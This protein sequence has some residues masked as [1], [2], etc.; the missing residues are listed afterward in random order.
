M[1]V[2]MQIPREIKIAISR[3]EREFSE[4]HANQKWK[5]RVCPKLPDQVRIELISKYVTKTRDI[6]PN[7]I[8]HVHKTMAYE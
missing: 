6:F 7:Q 1:E 4:S 2:E 5:L 3:I 8:P